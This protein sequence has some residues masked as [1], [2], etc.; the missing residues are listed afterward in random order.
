MM[1]GEECV[2]GLRSAQC[3]VSALVLWTGL[4]AGQARAIEL[5][6]EGE[7]TVLSGSIKT[8]D[9]KVFRDYVERE[10]KPAREDDDMLGNSWVIALNSPGGSLA[11]G[12]EIGRIMHEYALVSYIRR[13]DVCYSACAIAFLG[14]VFQYVTGRGPQRRMDVGGTL[15]FHG[16][17]LEDSKVVILNEA[18]DQA[19]ALNGLVL[20]YATEMR[21]I[22]LGF[23]SELLNVPATSIKLIN[24]PSALKKLGI[25]LEAPLPERPKEAGYNVCYQAVRKLLPSLEDVSDDRLERNPVMIAEVKA[26]MKRL[27]GDLTWDE[28][29]SQ[30][31]LQALLA[32]M[33]VKDG[34]DLLTGR[35]LYLDQIK[36]PVERYP[37]GRGGGF[38]YDQCY[39]FFDASG[40]GATSAAVTGQSSWVWANHGPLDFFAPDEPL[41]K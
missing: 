20:E 19:R 38:Y 18:F 7:L 5:T 14:G 11:D 3:L 15:G 9:A 39:V 30:R 2:F 6:R 13:D 23:L 4:F 12:I 32:T 25:R 10:L 8:G 40:D 31:K 33:P 29:D 35:N 37:L 34:M 24:T 41:W 22:D 36:W 17:K 27:V 21:A 28:A 16:Y 26:L 1:A